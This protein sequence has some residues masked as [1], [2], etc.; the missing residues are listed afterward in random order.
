MA[1]NLDS[2]QLD[3]E[4]IPK[5]LLQPDI[6]QDI[7]GVR[8]GN[9]ATV[10]IVQEGG[11][12][13][14]YKIFDPNLKL[15][16]SNSHVSIGQLLQDEAV[17]QHINQ[18]WLQLLITNQVRGLQVGREITPDNV[19]E[20]FTELYVNF[21]NRAYLVGYSMEY[22]AGT[23]MAILDGYQ[24]E[25]INVENV[26]ANLLIQGIY[27][28]NPTRLSQN[29]LVNSQ[30]L[31]WCFFDL[32]IDPNAITRNYTAIHGRKVIRE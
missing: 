7:L 15:P 26:H 25:G 30:N 31:T 24:I 10:F 27:C 17:I 9:N 14:C 6:V 20:I 28:G 13:V 12:T 11:N 23:P 18:E 32:E 5:Q 3:Q 16:D 4:S 19:L 29:L 1:F 21:N 22:F 8:N 2:G